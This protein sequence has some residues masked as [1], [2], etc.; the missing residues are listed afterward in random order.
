MPFDLL[1]ITVQPAGH[2]YLVV[3]S[4]ESK[5]SLPKGNP[6]LIK[7]S[8]PSPLHSQNGTKGIQPLGS[9]PEVT[10]RIFPSRR[11][12]FHFDRRQVH[13]TCRAWYILRRLARADLSASVTHLPLE[14][15]GSP[16]FI[17]QELTRPS[18]Q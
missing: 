3:T 4:E 5:V 13:L 16:Q 2:T 9:S 12:T 7:I 6:Q 1:T 11:K 17:S 15:S 10:H 14:A 8:F 18:Q